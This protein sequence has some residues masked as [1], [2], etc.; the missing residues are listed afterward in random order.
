MFLTTTERTQRMA[1]IKEGLDQQKPIDPISVRELLAWFNAERRGTQVVYWVRDLLRTHEVETVPDFES[2][3]LDTPVSFILSKSANDD[4]E[5]IEEL[6]EEEEEE[7]DNI[8]EGEV[9][10]ESAVSRRLVVGALAEPAFRIGRLLAAN[11]VPLYVAP[12]CTL[13]EAVTLMLRHDFSQ[14]PVMSS[15]RDVKGVVSWKSIGPTL[16]LSAEA[17]AGTVRE[18]M[19]PHLEVD[20]DASLFSVIPTIIENSYVLV[21][22]LD[23]KIQGIVTSTDLSLQFKQLSEPFLL[24]GEIENHIRKL[25]DGRFDADELGSVKD[26]ADTERII[27]NVA[28][29]TF[30]EYV[31]LLGKAEFWG[32]LRISIDRKVFV[33]ELDLIRLIRNRVMHFDADGISPYDYQS[34]Y[35]FV[36]FIH[37]VRRLQIRADRKAAT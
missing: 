34:L 21:R 3:P 5:E 13:Q 1:A 26:N 31:A 2:V 35:K 22:G 15:E 12:D 27:A 29:L 36:Q 33:K 10:A 16:A 11:T 30:G 7:Q 4:E 8:A 37:E 20:A 25:I 28:D 14:L 23:R 17:P 24:L 9:V 18:H 32:K 19:K 6:E